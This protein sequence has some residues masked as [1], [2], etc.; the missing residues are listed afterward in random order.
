MDNGKD[1]GYEDQYSKKLAS[2]FFLKGGAH[3]NK[4]QKFA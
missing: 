3:L 1:N 4:D 2:M